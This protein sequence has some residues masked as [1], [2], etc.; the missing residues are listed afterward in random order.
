MV[1]T[2]NRID[3]EK[4]RS[5]RT[6]SSRTKNYLRQTPISDTPAAASTHSHKV[7]TKRLSSAVNE[8]NN[9]SSSSYANELKQ[10]Q[11]CIV[12]EAFENTERVVEKAKS[13]Y[14]SIMNRRQRLKKIQEP[15]TGLKDDQPISYNG[16]TPTTNDLN[17][18]DDDDDHLSNDKGKVVKLSKGDFMTMKVVGQFNLG[19]ILALS[20]KGDLWILDQHACDEQVSTSKAYPFQTKEEK[21]T[22]L[23]PNVIHQYCNNSSTSNV[24][25]K[26]RKSTN[27]NF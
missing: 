8:Q 27:K 20:D 13:M 9:E 21:E 3:E 12:W 6:I 25:A 14:I 23:T 2:N 16:S 4:V 5:P 1:R 19:F 22:N 17:D 7:T 26:K 10:Q 15:K 18:V 24:S 11:D